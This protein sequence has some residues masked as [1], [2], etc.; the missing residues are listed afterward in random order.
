VVILWPAII[1]VVM[2][3]SAE[4]QAY[5]EAAEVYQ[6]KAATQLVYHLERL[7]LDRSWHLL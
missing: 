6:S 7:L 4:A 5:L 1:V 2:L 3:V